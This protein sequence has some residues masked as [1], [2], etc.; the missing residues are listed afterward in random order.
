MPQ[1]GCQHA[2]HEKPRESRGNNWLAPE[3]LCI[4]WRTLPFWTR[5][6]ERKFPKTNVTS[7]KTLKSWR[8]SEK[9]GEHDERSSGKSDIECFFGSGRELKVPRQHSILGRFSSVLQPRTV[10]RKRREEDRPADITESS[11]TSGFKQRASVF[12]AA[13]AR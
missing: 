10:R 11:S 7:T 6:Y 3:I 4:W 2:R 9:P 13:A 12:V 5:R 8:V 1:K